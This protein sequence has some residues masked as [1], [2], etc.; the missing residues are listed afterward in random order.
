MRLEMPFKRGT[1]QGPAN[2][3]IFAHPAFV[4]MIAAWGAAVCGLSVFVLPDTSAFLAI[5]AA[6][7][8]G[9][10]LYLAARALN[11]RS[12]PVS[13]DIG[14]AAEPDEAVLPI[15]PAQDLG[16]DSLDAPIEDMFL[17]EP[18]HPEEEPVIAEEPVEAEDEE[19]AVEPK[20]EVAPPENTGPAPKPLPKSALEELRQTPTEELS[21]VQMV[22][23][24]AAAL[25]DYQ[26]QEHA[27]MAATGPGRDVALAEALKA[28]DL[29]TERG[30]DKGGA[31]TG[32]A[33]LGET[34]RELQA[35]LTKLQNLRGAA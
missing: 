22:E 35:A 29:F 32:T 23:R 19:P 11:A 31:A 18:E 10:F 7:L 1:R 5:A 3:S 6:I 28:L 33:N 13:S 16:S 34:E 30:F 17:F 14:V 2:G 4:P 20:E 15:N 8:G 9:A 12:A 24:F 26:K 21:L 27:R 25:H